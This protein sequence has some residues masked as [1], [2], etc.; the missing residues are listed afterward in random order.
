[1]T[2]KAISELFRYKELVY[3]L[4]SRDLKVRY[5]RSVLGV[6]WAFIEPM[7]MMFLFTLVF[8]YLLKI[9]IDKYPVFVL[10]G[11]LAWNFFLTGVNYSLSSISSNANLIKKIY[12]PKEILPLS[13]IAGRLINFILSLLLLVPF[14]IW[15][16]VPLGVSIL[17]LPVVIA[18]Q[19]VLISGLSLLLSSLNTF[20]NDV[21]FLANFI[22]MGFFYLTP[23][24]YSVDMVPERFRTVYMLNPMAAVITAYRDVLIYSRLP[25]M[26]YF[27]LAAALSLFIFVLGLMVF[28]RAEHTFAEV[29]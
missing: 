16:R 8:S 7:A 18:V 23:V 4:V 5:K 26:G 2:F 13:T 15:F 3:N 21:G 1:M 9:K 29:L 27:G 25:D 19:L 17:F 14:F 20:Y 28:K 6:A 22:F 10:T 12:F 24:F 11:L